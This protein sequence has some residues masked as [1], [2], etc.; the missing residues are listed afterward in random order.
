MC[1]RGR[2]DTGRRRLRRRDRWPQSSTARVGK[3]LDEA[4]LRTSMRELERE[5]E[6]R[7]RVEKVC[8]EL[9]GGVLV[10][11]EVLR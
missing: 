5:R 6:E 2:P 8:D 7:E 9:A 1:V 3:K 10:A 4:S 11:E